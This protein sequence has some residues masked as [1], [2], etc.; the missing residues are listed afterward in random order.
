MN[1]TN[2]Q[3]IS[4]QEKD[5]LRD[6][7]DVKIWPRSILDLDPNSYCTFINNVKILAKFNYKELEYYYCF[8]VDPTRFYFLHRNRV[9]GEER[10]FIYEAGTM[11]KL[12]KN[13]NKNH[14]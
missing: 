8:R 7:C 9:A 2:F 14:L 1:E 11:K 10:V 13:F 6:S 3:A 12:L 5:W 4:Q